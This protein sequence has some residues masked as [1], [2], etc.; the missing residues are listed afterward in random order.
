MDHG[1]D[2]FV[3]EQLVDQH[4]LAAAVEH[5]D[6]RHAAVA[7]VGRRPQQAGTRRIGAGCQGFRIRRADRMGGRAVDEDR[8]F[9]QGDD[10]RHAEGAGE[11]H[12]RR[13]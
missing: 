2:A 1:A 10:F 11:L 13:V 8:L 7:G 6:A 3:G 9:E 12:H 4:A 5:V